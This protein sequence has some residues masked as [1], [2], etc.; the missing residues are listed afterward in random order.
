MKTALLN[1]I[2][3]NLGIDI[4]PEMGS[5]EIPAF[6]IDELTDEQKNA[7]I[8]T[9]GDAGK[10]VSHFY[11][12]ETPI[13][14]LDILQ[15]NAKLIFYPQGLERKGLEHFPYFNDVEIHIPTNTLRIRFDYIKGV[16]SFFDETTESF[17]EL[18]QTFAGTIVFRPKSSVL[19]V[20]AK[21]ASMA[22]KVAIRTARM[23]LPPFFPMSLRE[24][25]YINRFL[26]WI[27]S[28]N[29][30]RIDLPISDLRR[31]MT[32]VARRGRDL[33]QL[34]DF[35]REMRLGRLRGGH[36]TI[37]KSKNHFVKFNIFFKPCHAWFTS[38]STNKDIEFVVSALEKIVE[39][40]EFAHP[41]R[42]LDY[43]K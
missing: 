12:C 30:A 8:E 41:E 37:E 14:D 29:N 16:Y 25:K 10:P 20:R 13:P 4:P 31:S 43:F 11:V 22:R 21:H 18:R 1:R 2:A 7:I 19:E 40:Y 26:D 24:Q 9:Y 5:F 39:G 34:N 6:L 23:K 36:V 28:L 33:R 17:K 32:I 38:Y 35:N 15:E 27:Y 3:A 42:L